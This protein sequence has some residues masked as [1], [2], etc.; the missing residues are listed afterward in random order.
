[1]GLLKKIVILAT[2]GVIGVF[3]AR[4][5]QDN[6]PLIKASEQESELVNNYKV[7]VYGEIDKDGKFVL[8]AAGED[9][10]REKFLPRWQ[11]INKEY[12]RLIES[13]DLQQILGIDEFGS[14][15]YSHENVFTR[16][17]NVLGIPIEALQ[18]ADELSKFVDLNNPNRT[19][20]IFCILDS[21]KALHPWLSAL[22][23]YEE[24]KLRERQ[25]P[26]T[27]YTIRFLNKTAIVNASLIDYTGPDSIPDG[28]LDSIV[29]SHPYQVDL[30]KHYN[31]TPLYKRISGYGLFSPNKLEEVILPAEYPLETPT[32]LE[33]LPSNKSFKGFNSVSNYFSN[34]RKLLI[35]ADSFLA[36]K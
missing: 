32:E 7:P 26:N 18:T 27:L 9:F 3:G 11:E 5:L 21:D 1:M 17:E 12:T 16:R 2:A 22:S 31:G 25:G 13:K 30:E 24:G 4:G 10:Y 20:R 19:L 23:I 14:V 28:N 36:S 8:I 15:S 33:I 6:K 35:H 29:L 34:V